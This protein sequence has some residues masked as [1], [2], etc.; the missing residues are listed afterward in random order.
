MTKDCR[1]GH[2]S[3]G[4][5]TLSRSN[6]GSATRMRT[7][8]SQSLSKKKRSTSNLSGNKQGLVN[9]YFRVLNNQISPSG[10]IKGALNAS[11]KGYSSSKT[12]L[13]KPILNVN[14]INSNCTSNVSTGRYH[15][16]VSKPGS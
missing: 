14:N 15:S 8:K 2:K 11:S 1:Q 12:K 6:S 7:N 13:N 3:K 9:K 5:D 4:K 10:Q 16:N